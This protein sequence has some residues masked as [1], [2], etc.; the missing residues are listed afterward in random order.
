MSYKKGSRKTNLL[1]RF[2]N[3]FMQADFQEE[4]EREGR[5]EGQG[6]IHPEA[7]GGWSWTGVPQPEM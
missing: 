5:P 4:A 2:G 1:G 7:A 6:S 3:W